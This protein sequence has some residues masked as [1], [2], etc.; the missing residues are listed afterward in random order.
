MDLGKSDARV[1]KFPVELTSFDGVI[2]PSK[3]EELKKQIDN[4]EVDERDVWICSYPKTG[5]TW[6]REMVWM[7]VNDCNFKGAEIPLNER[8]PFLEKAGLDVQDASY[9]NALEQIKNRKDG[10]E[11]L[12]IKT[13]LPFKLLPREITSQVK[14]PKI[15]YITRNAKDTCVS[16]YHFIKLVWG[17]R[18]D[19]SEFCELFLGEKAPYSPFWNHVLPFWQMRHNPNVLF[20]RYEEMKSDLGGVIRRVSQFLQKPMT[21]EQIEVLIRHLDFDSMKKNPAVNSAALHEPLRKLHPEGRLLRKGVVGD[22]KTIMSLDMQK[23][24]DEW[25][26]SNIQ[27]TD[28][29][30]I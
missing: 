24:F 16:Y 7:I 9:T 25:T 21:D 30:S 17:Y 14:K 3:Y 10:K 4:L 20:L 2:L 13:H 27:D 1:K 18:S 23:R 26:A 8:S 5:S 11:S 29:Y 6:T 22:H 28:Y 19:F 12:I 15:I